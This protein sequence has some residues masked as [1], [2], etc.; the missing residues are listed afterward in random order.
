[1]GPNG[2]QLDSTPDPTEMNLATRNFRS[3]DARVS[4]PTGVPRVFYVSD[5]VKLGSIHS[6]NEAW[7]LTMSMY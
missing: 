4:C 6:R 7:R 5:G 1:M 2:L 3:R